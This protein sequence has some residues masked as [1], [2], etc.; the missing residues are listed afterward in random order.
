MTSLPEAEKKR[1]RQVAPISINSSR[2]PGARI[3]FFCLSL[4]LPF[5]IV[6]W[7]PP[8][9]RQSI[10]AKLLKIAQILQICLC[11]RDLTFG[12]IFSS[13]TAKYR[14]LLFIPLPHI[15]VPPCHGDRGPPCFLLGFSLQWE[16]QFEAGKNFLSGK[17]ARCWKWFLYNILML[18]GYYSHLLQKRWEFLYPRRH[19]KARRRRPPSTTAGKKLNS[20]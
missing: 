3:F 12:P 19:E 14:R 5:S 11:V 13:K 4:A 15:G 1:S 10:P 17:F 2:S 18:S 20:A 8:T 16:S 6:P 9:E 7:L